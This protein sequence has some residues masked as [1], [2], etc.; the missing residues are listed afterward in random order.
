MRTAASPESQCYRVL[1]FRAGQ[2]AAA[3]LLVLAPALEPDAGEPAHGLFSGRTTQQPYSRD[4]P[5]RR[6]MARLCLRRSGSCST[7]SS[8]F[9][10]PRA[11]PETDCAIDCAT[12]ALCS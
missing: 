7:V 11:L 12:V 1:H 6:P 5:A 3:T 8:T 10:S 4:V 2:F 9:R